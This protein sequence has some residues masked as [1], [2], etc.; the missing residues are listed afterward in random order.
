MIDELNC[1]FLSLLYYIEDDWKTF[2]ETKSKS[3]MSKTL[4]DIKI[5]IKLPHISYKVKYLL[6]PPPTP[7]NQ[8]KDRFKKGFSSKTRPTTQ[9]NRLKFNSHIKHNIL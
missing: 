4:I 6:N 3:K 9:K 1:V 2:L 7:Y 8:K 5:H